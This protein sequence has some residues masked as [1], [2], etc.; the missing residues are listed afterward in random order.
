MNRQGSRPNRPLGLLLLLSTAIQLF[1]TAC[2]RTDRKVPPH[3]PDI[4]RYVTF[5][6]VGDRLAPVDYVLGLFDQADV[7][8]LGERLHSETTQYDLVMD[9][10]SDPRFIEQVGNIFT[11]IGSISTE[12]GITRFLDA[13][14]LTDAE[15][16]AWRMRIYRDF[17]R[18]VLWGRFNYYD[19]LGRVYDL[20]QSLARE[21]KIH[22]HPVDK[23]FRWEGM[24]REAYDREMSS[25][26]DRDLR[27]A[28]NVVNG[29][30]A[31]AAAHGGTAK[32]LVI[33]NFR[34]AFTHLVF[35][36]GDTLHNAT[37]YLMEMLPGQVRNVMIN[38]VAIVGGTSDA[39]IEL[40]LV[41]DGRWDAAFEVTGDRP[42]GF[43]F[44]GSPF[45]MDG[46][47]YFPFG[48]EGMTYADIFTGFI[49]YQPVSAHRLVEGVPGIVN[50][51]FASELR[52][53]MDIAASYYGTDEE[54]ETYLASR[55]RVDTVSYET[56]ARVPVPF[57]TAMDRWIGGPKR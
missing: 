4:D 10:I 8:V 2:E 6:T 24:T 35:P 53:R 23:P 43:D 5:L 3:S 7:V 20:N 19:M 50:D 34:H 13:E 37:G 9:I 32:A 21:R 28:E 40:G 36:N 15:R 22:L 46:F 54:R 47:D 55:A 41:Q 56:T 17:S 1:V 27:I 11:E 14:G 45:G 16:D 31:I 38:S 33:M 51:S 39:D 49:F 12:P 30:H 18:E 44:D 48:T 25:T 57:R 52:R 29:L 42:V 26:G